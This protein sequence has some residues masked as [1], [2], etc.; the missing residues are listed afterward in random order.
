MQHFPCFCALKGCASSHGMWD[1]LSRQM[2]SLLCLDQMFQMAPLT[3]L[4]SGK[5]VFFRAQQCQR[6]PTQSS[7]FIPLLLPVTVL[8]LAAS[9][10]LLNDASPRRLQEVNSM[11]NKRLKDVLFSDQWSELCMDTLSPFG[12]VLVSTA[13]HTIDYYVLYNSIINL[14]YHADI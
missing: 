11:L 8:F 2:T 5:Q 12:F 13:L 14:V 3:C 10:S 6:V 9:F 4:S 7:V 1:Q